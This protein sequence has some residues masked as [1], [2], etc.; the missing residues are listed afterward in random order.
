MCKV[1]GSTIAKEMR[2]EMA[3]HFNGIE[4]LQKPHVFVFASVRICLQC[5]FAE[6]VIEESQLALIK[7]DGVQK[8]FGAAV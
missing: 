1:C 3:L 8:A 6:F 5:G 2:S 4:N 7:Q